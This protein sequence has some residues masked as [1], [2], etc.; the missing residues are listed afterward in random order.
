MHI[1]ARSWHLRWVRR[2][3]GSGYTPRDLCSYFWVVVA[4]TVLPVTAAIVLQV[5]LGLL[6]WRHPT[7][8]L[9]A[10]VMAVL[11]LALT[12]LLFFVVFL[13]KFLSRAL[14]HDPERP[15]NLVVEY[16]R[17]KKRRLCPLLTVVEEP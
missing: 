14:R 6:I 15:P 10:L 9:I 11:S 8:I 5:G 3:F 7:E 17:A 4:L 16:L 1:S 12:A 13:I 2:F